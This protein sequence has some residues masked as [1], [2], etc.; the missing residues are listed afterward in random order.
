VTTRCVIVDDSRAFLAA[1]RVLH[2]E[3]PLGAVGA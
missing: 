2:V 3:R 1:T